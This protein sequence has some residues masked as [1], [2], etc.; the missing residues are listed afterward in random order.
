M[1]SPSVATALKFW[2]DVASGTAMFNQLFT[3]PDRR[4]GSATNQKSD[5]QRRS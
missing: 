5:G 1:K 4:G 2:P 3:P